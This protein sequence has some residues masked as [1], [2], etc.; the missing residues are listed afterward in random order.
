[1][2]LTDVDYSLCGGSAAT[3]CTGRCVNATAGVCVRLLRTLYPSFAWGIRWIP[4]LLKP[5][6]PTGRF[7]SHEGP[8]SCTSV[9][10]CVCVI[11]P[12][13]VDKTVPFPQTQSL[14]IKTARWWDAHLARDGRGK[15][16]LTA[17]SIQTDRQ[18]DR[19]AHKHKH[20][21]GLVKTKQINTVIAHESEEIWGSVT[22]NT[23]RI[24]S[25][26]LVSA[27]GLSV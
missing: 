21:K 4:L 1:M 13:L 20:K 17:Q 10:V 7:G 11:W 25:L 18:T 8:S 22:I 2:V 27:V 14:G 23:S 12:D 9:C 15:I 26:N 6:D 3:R 19:C 24:F 5:I 16:W